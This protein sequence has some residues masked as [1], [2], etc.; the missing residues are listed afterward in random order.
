MR[1]TIL[2]RL[3]I[4]SC[5]AILTACQ[6]AIPPSKPTQEVAV[7]FPDYADATIP[8]NIAPLNFSLT[9]PHTEAY[10]LLQVGQERLQL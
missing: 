7:L 6:G 4:G 2:Y 9:N 10:A 1:N 5:V 3:L 8:A